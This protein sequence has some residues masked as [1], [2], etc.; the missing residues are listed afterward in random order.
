MGSN[1]DSSG[2][3]GST[4]PTSTVAP[5][6]KDLRGGLIDWL[7]RNGGQNAPS[8]TGGVPTY[9]PGAGNG[10]GAP[11]VTGVPNS[12]IDRSWNQLT[13]GDAGF[14]GNQSHSP[15]NDFGRIFNPTVQQYTAQ[16]AAGGQIGDLPSWL[17][18][19]IG[20][21][22]PITAGQTNGAA[23]QA[24]TT[25]AT[26]STVQND[27][28]FNSIADMLRAGNGPGSNV[29][30]G[31]AGSTVGMVKSIDDVVNQQNGAG[32]YFHDSV[33]S[34]YK[35]LFSQQR[36]EALAQA[37]ESAGNLTGSGFANALGTTTNRSIVDENKQL[38]DV[39]TQLGQFEV[40]RQQNV[41]D[42]EQGRLNTNAGL[43]TQANV[44][45][46]NNAAGGVN[47]LLSL[48]SGQSIANAG[49]ANQT[50]MFNAGEANKSGIDFAGRTDA[51]NQFNVNQANNAAAENARLETQKAIEQ[52]RITSGEA[53]NF[54]NQ[55]VAKQ[56][57]QARLD[58]NNNQFN[59]GEQNKAGAFNAGATNQNNQFNSSQFAQLLQ[60]L[61]GGGSGG[62]VY[63]PG[64]LDSIA[65]LIP[66]LALAK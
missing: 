33:L 36:G 13:G 45:G 10:N 5:D 42:R 6:V 51:N 29:T 27:P 49:N 55:Q 63:K 15:Y 58:Q 48:L 37:K 8:N 32:G 43:T 26:A 25:N 34:P 50:S 66:G 30:A 57:E 54:Y 61:T 59:A 7:G 22:N 17:N 39:L 47:N 3:K 31:Q 44:A 24:P 21:T 12:P 52:G 60:A 46:A 64:A 56:T 40:G 53:Q 11:G 38:S 20:G 2:L 14:P 1:V 23:G 19:I 65:Q 28:R 16:N 18:T 41:A 4:Q 35:A 62:S 9:N